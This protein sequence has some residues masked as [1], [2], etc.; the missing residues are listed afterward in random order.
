VKSAKKLGLVVCG[1]TSAFVSTAIITG[2]YI[3]KAQAA[4]VN[5]VENG[6]F[7]DD[8]FINEDYD[9]TRPNPFFTG[10]TNDSQFFGVYTTYLSSYANS[11]IQGIRLGYT[12]D[13]LSASLSQTLKTKKNK[14]YRLSFYLASAE[15]APR[16][17][18]EFKVFVDGD[19]VFGL[20]NI[21]LQDYTRYDVDFTATSKRTDLKFV[22]KVGY[23]WLNL[24]DVSVY[25]TK[26]IDGAAVPEP[27]TLGGTAVAGLLGVWLRK[28][29]A[30]SLKQS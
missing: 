19:E 6:S 12:P 17:G 1:V 3:P 16:L 23:D 2:T 25:R 22:S 18:N 4:K 28:K 21:T 24:D 30:A 15:E 29:Q 5:L 11:G 8:P 14:E 13:D 9:P 7:E 20:T 27:F 26:D 10:W